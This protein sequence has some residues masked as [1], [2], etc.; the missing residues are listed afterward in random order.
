MEEVRVLFEEFHRAIGP[1]KAESSR[2]VLLTDV[3]GDND[4]LFIF[5]SWLLEDNEREMFFTKKVR[6]YLCN[7]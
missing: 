7:S 2:V 1:L 6:T 5:I 4:V 3:L